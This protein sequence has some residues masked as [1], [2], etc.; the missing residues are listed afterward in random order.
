MKEKIDQYAKGIFEYHMPEVVLGTSELSVTVDAGE[1]VQG[2]FRISN[3]KGR[4]MRGIVCTDCSGMILEKRAFPDRRM[5]F[6]LLFV[7][8]IISREISLRENFRSFLT[9]VWLCCH[10]LLQSRYH[11]AKP[12]RDGSVI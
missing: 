11:T 5:T 7:E 10:L 3:S 2:S 6:P 4:S 9:A 1:I 12:L 8:P